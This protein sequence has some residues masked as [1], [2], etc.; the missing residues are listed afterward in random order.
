VRPRESLLSQTVLAIDDSPDIHLLLDVRLRPEGLVL[1]HALSAEEGLA[2]A[3]ELR[4]D[5]ILLDV[6]LPLVTGFEVC[7]KLKDNPATASIPIIFLTGAAEVHTKVQGFDLGAVDYVVKPFEP[8][9]LRARV[10]AALRTKRFHDLLSARS[11]VDGLTGIWNR[12]YFNQRF[13]E[14]ISAAQRY[15]RTVTLVMLD[16]DHFKALNDSF[17]HPFGD[18]VLQTMGDILHACLRTTDAPCRYG[19]EEF[20]LVL[21]E[22][23]EPGAKVTAERVRLEIA[24]HAFRPKDKHVQVTASLGIA[25][26]SAFDR[27]SLSMSTVVTAADD[28]LYQA[29]AEGRNR[30]CVAKRS[31]EVQG[32]RPG[33]SRS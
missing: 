2:R 30:V 11:H 25:C 17:G 22:T 14:E 18:Q 16:L 21:T 3:L 1:H 7:Q 24:Q 12:S 19:G 26:S 33:R 13:G 29:K 27:E 32:G 31:L 15:G 28:A 4:P 6:N 23:D 8:A 5:L 20:A 9:E 10:R